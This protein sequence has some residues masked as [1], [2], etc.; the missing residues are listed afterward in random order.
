MV[1]S[2]VAAAT[3]AAG[4]DLKHML[5]LCKPAPAIG[6]RATTTRSPADRQART[7][8]GQGVRQSLFRRRE[9]VSA[10]AINTPQGIIL[11]DALNNGKEAAQ[12]IEGGLRRLGLNPARIKY[13]VVTH[14][15]GDHYGGATI[16]STSITPAWWRA[17]K[18][19][20]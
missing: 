16:W 7:A 14:G 19:G 3:K 12:L 20:R 18:T 9:W 1:Q 5:A 10:W 17:S 2:H 8:A 11:I 13:I 4:T 15:H 6:R